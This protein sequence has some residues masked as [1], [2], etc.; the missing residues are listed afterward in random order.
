MFF[1]KV[2]DVNIC[3]AAWFT[4]MWRIGITSIQPSSPGKNSH[5]NTTRRQD[6]VSA[7][8]TKLAPIAIIAIALSGCSR[9]LHEASFTAATPVTDWG[10]VKNLSHDGGVYFG[11]QP[12][13][14][15]FGTAQEMGVRVVVNLRSDPEIAAMDFDEAALVEQLGM[16]YVAIPITSETFAPA[17]ADDLKEVLRK[18]SGPVLIHCASSNRVGALWAMYLHRHRGVALDQAIALGR[19]AG[20]RSEGLVETIRETAD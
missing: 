14:D 9:S 6:M 15:A 5:T 1:Q 17:D 12:T 8:V 7:G 19:K 13:A 10:G 2:A 18:T 16:K 4:Q 3:V 11:G 20:L